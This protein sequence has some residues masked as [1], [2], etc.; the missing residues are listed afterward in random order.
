V[1]LGPCH[2]APRHTAAPQR[3]AEG[4]HWEAFEVLLAAAGVPTGDGD[5]VGTTVLHSAA[6]GG[7]WR[8]VQVR[9][10]CTPAAAPGAAAAQAPG[11]DRHAL[12]PPAS[13]P[14]SP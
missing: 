3:A 10:G 6:L 9:G 7:S 11:L 8:I 13:Q 5:G 12:R 1:A 14:A 2:D 4:G